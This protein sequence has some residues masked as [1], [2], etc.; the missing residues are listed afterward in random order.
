MSFVPQLPSGFEQPQNGPQPG[1]KLT[2]DGTVIVR[3]VKTGLVFKV[4]RN[5][6]E[7]VVKSYLK[8]PFSPYNLK[9]D[10]AC[11]WDDLS[12]YH[13][14]GITS[15]TGVIVMVSYGTKSMLEKL[16]EDYAEERC[17]GRGWSTKISDVSFRT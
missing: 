4:E 12:V 14:D 3:S 16:H 7:V 13:R 15:V 9:N 2:R 6:G 10:G 1:V 11:K 5:Y 8:L 17:Y